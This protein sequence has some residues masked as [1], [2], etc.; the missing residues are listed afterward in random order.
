[1]KTLIA[2][3][4]LMAVTTAFAPQPLQYVYIDDNPKATLYHA[5]TDCKDLLKKGHGKILKVT[6]N[7]AVNKYKRKPCPDC[8]KPMNK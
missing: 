2:A 1:M 3:I 8:Y 5:A 7:D 4:C 6:L